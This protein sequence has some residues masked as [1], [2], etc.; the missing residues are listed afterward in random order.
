MAAGKVSRSDRIRG[1][2]VVVIGSS[3]FA[4]MAD[5]TFVRVLA[6]AVA[7]MM[8]LSV[9]RLTATRESG[10]HPSDQPVTPNWQR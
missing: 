9:G 7:V 3:A 2:V 4:I 10:E 6:T 1:G 5:T 8:A